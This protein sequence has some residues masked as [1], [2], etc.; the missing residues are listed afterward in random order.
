MGYKKVLM[1][2]A[3]L[4]AGGMGLALASSLPVLVIIG[5]AMVGYGVSTVIPIAY[6]VAGRSKTMRPSVALAA[7][8][9]VGFTG[10]LIGPPVIGFIAHEIG[11]R[12]ALGLVIILAMGVFFLSSRIKTAH[13]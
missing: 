5:F 2:D 7:V 4:I 6:M 1:V 11:L 12:Y 10:F 13:S 9:T 8:S 3:L